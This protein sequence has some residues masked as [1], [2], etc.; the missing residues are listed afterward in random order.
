MTTVGGGDMCPEST[1]GRITA[2]FTCLLGVMLLGFLFTVISDKLML[3]ESA[4]KAV[5]WVDLS[6][7]RETRQVLAAKVIQH[8][9]RST[10]SHSDG[11]AHAGGAHYGS[12]VCGPAGCHQ[13]QQ[14]QQRQREGLSHEFQQAKHADVQLQIEWRKQEEIAELSACVKVLAEQM[15]RMEARFGGNEGEGKGRERGTHAVAPQS[16]S[17]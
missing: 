2:S 9:A 10:T 7:S 17:T 16:R 5:R 3:S 15:A 12:G 6:Q 8:A 14:Q 4:Q 13:Q 11:V 1:M